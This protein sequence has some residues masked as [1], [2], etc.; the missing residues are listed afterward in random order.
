MMFIRMP[1]E[2][3]AKIQEKNG[4]QPGLS[5]KELLKNSEM[6]VQEALTK[7]TD[8]VLIITEEKKVIFANECA[9]RILRQINQ[10]QE[11]TEPIPREINYLCNSLSDIR[12]MFPGQHWMM[13]TKICISSAVTFNVHARYMKLDTLG[14]YC[15]VLVLKDQY[16]LIKTIA[17]EEAQKFNLTDRETE[18]WL[19]QRANY[20]YKQIASEL[21][22]APNTVKKHMQN[23]HLKQKGISDDFIQQMPPFKYP[24]PVQEGSSRIEDCRD[25]RDCSE[26]RA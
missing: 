6:I 25:R 10:D 17:V 22:I 21:F 26:K 14:K 4:D 12:R 2:N 7:L 5:G 20:T 24:N 23:I 15:I 18:I 3:L 1:V 16:Q 13:T 19:L 11:N 8:G 9:C